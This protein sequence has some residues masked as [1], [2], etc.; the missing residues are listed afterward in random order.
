MFLA[1][2]QLV[3]T[4]Y[5]PAPHDQRQAKFF[6]FP[7]PHDTLYFPA[8]HDQWRAFFIAPCDEQ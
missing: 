1:T 2:P 7:A 6:I 4:L 5:F 3:A 8:L